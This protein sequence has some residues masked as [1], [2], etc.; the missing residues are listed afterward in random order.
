[1][2][3]SGAVVRLGLAEG[4]VFGL[5]GDVVVDRDLRTEK[6]PSRVARESAPTC[7]SRPL[8]PSSSGVH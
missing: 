4:F 1:M 2:V 3:L 5:W 6:R 8:L 7:L